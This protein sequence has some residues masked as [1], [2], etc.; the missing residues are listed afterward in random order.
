M[1]EKARPVAPVQNLV[2][3]CDGECHSRGECVGDVHTYEIVRHAKRDPIWVGMRFN[4]CTTAF[5]EDR[6]RGFFMK[7]VEDTE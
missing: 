3:R 5:L 7:I 4:Y 2:R 1:P 6:S